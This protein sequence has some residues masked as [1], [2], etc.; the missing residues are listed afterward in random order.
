[1]TPQEYPFIQ[2]TILFLQL[3]PTWE[4]VKFSYISYQFPLNMLIYLYHFQIIV[5]IMECNICHSRK[6]KK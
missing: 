4:N 1:M 2:F 6:Q 5:L 3:F